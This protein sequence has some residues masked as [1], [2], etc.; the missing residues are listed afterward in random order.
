MRISIKI[1][2]AI[3]FFSIV[4][5]AIVNYELLI[6]EIG[7]FY[8]INILTNLVYLI[9]TYLCISKLKKVYTIIG[10]VIIIIGITVNLLNVYYLAGTPFLSFYWCFF[11]L[12]NIQK[13]PSIIFQNLL[14]VFLIILFIKKN[15]PATTSPS[16]QQ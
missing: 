1:L 13:N 7:S 3:S 11:D 14:Y 5:W 15:Y 9:I 8:L 16:L 6:S 12:F 2:L 4:T 10:I